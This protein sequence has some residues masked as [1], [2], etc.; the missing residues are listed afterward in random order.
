MA[1]A[2]RLWS[3]PTLGLVLLDVPGKPFRGRHGRRGTD[4]LALVYPKLVNPQRYLCPPQPW[5]WLCNLLAAR[6]RILLASGSPRRVLPQLLPRARASST[7]LQQHLM[8]TGLQ[9]R[10]GA[11]LLLYG[12][13][14]ALHWA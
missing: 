14:P 11:R 12:N 5:A 3:G 10:A 4:H 7:R 9:R 1:V 13:V 8:G 2:A 6:G